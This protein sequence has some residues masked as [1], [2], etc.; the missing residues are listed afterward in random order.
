VKKGENDVLDF[1][2]VAELFLMVL[3]FDTQTSLESY[4][5]EGDASRLLV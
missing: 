3:E 4:F 2:R 5:Y 1:L